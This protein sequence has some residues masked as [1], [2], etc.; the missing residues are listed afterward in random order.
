MQQIRIEQVLNFNANTIACTLTGYTSGAGTISSTDTILQSI[1]KLNGNIGS[2]TTGVSSV[3]SRTGVVIAQSGDYT[4]ALVTE[5]GNLYLTNARVIA[6]TLTGYISGAGS[7]SSSD[8]MLSAMQKLDGNVLAMV[9]GVSSVFG[10]AGAVIAQINDYT[11]AQL[12]STPTTLAGY[13]ITDAYTKTVSD[14][15][16]IHNASSLQTGAQF[17]VAV[18]TVTGST[19]ASVSSFIGTNSS[20]PLVI[21]WGAGGDTTNASTSS[22]GGIAAAVNYRLGVGGNSLNGFGGRGGDIEWDAGNGGNGGNGGGRGGDAIYRAGDGGTGTGSQGG[23]VGIK[24][25][26][27]GIGSNGNGGNIFLSPGSK[28][29]GTG[30][31]GATYLNVSNS[32]TIRGNVIIGSITDNLSNIFQVTG[33]SLFIGSIGATSIT[34]TGTAG[35]GVINYIAQGSTPSTPAASHQISYADSSGRFTLM[36][37][38]GFAASLSKGLLTASRIY[39]FP[40]VAGTLFIP[41]G[42]TSQYVVGDGTYATIITDN[43]SFTNGA[44]YLTSGTAGALYA[45]ITGSANYIQ[46]QT[47]APQTSS[48]FI[49]DGYGV[50]GGRLMLGGTSSSGLTATNLKVSNNVT[51][52]V[53]AFGIRHD[54][55]I[56]SDVTTEAD[57]FRSVAGTQA[58][59]FTLTTLIHFSTS[60]SALGAGSAITSQI[61]F[62]ASASLTGATSNYGFRGLL[63][64]SS[65]R[66]NLY[67]DGTAQN[68]IRGNLRVG[69][70]VDPTV[71]LDVTGAALISTTLGVT[72][73]TTF[74]GVTST[75][76][77]GT[78]KLV[79]DTFPAFPDGGATAAATFGSGSGLNFLGFSLSRGMFGYNGTN[80]NVS[81]TAGSAKGMEFFVNGT[82]GTLS[83]G[84]NALSIS[85]AGA[86][87]VATQ[88]V[89][90]NS[91]KVATTAYVKSPGA[92]TPTTVAP[93][94]SITIAVGQSLLM[95]E[96]SNG[97]VGQTTLVSGTKAITISGLTT[98]SRAIITLVSSSSASL[99][100]QYQG[101]CT[102]NT[103]TLQANI[104]AGTINTADVSVLNYLVIN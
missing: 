53:T 60:Q 87:T 17:N 50:I 100:I 62:Q 98:S 9:S 75:G 88:S 70:T 8:T 46:N 92:I 82:A 19:P 49:I 13:G 72:G 16:Y 77:T 3:F 52:G 35:T 63:A 95:T 41:V 93:T 23:D 39:S 30:L 45:P 58:T 85:S 44:G 6:S 18:A 86:V 84:T 15:N 79:Y 20:N 55:V 48:N 65:G 14:S 38:N 64:S 42:T 103:L 76:A 81:I 57:L 97:R 54:G 91:T 78:G 90:D 94:S 32:G 21:T 40:D 10:R 34:V 67:M 80:N 22:S 2:L 31:D 1:Q 102:T 36:G 83:T 89:N 66:Y 25:G 59:A 104:A 33:S 47:A 69:S 12:A 74:E 27:C 51:G 101:V 61:G 11:F 26:W 29:L 96:G 56:Q 5:S 7:I 68:V 71:A 28:N 99:T 4:T 43:A 24:G 37:S 73:H